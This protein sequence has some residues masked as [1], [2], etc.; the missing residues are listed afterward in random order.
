MDA[1]ARISQHYTVSFVHNRCRDNQQKEKKIMEIIQTVCEHI[2][3]TIEVFPTT[4]NWILKWFTKHVSKRDE[5][6]TTEV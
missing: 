6:S 3:S 1:G 4:H 5:S 2:T